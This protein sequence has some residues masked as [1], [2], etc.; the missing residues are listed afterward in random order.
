MNGGRSGRIH[1]HF[2]GT[3]LS[4]VDKTK[5]NGALLVEALPLLLDTMVVCRIVVISV[6]A[7]FEVNAREKGGIGCGAG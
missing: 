2:T 7:P 5:V 1:V 3:K 6:R 4:N